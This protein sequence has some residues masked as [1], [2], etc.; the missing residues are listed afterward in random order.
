VSPR[1]DSTRLEELHIEIGG[2]W[3]AEDMAAFLHDLSVLYDIR[4]AIDVEPRL[5]KY[6]DRYGPPPFS[7]GPESWWRWLPGPPGPGLE[8]R[9]IKY[10]SPGYIDL[11][12]LGEAVKQIRLLIERLISFNETRRE[13]RLKND[14]REQDVQAKMIENARDFLRLKTEVREQGFDDDAV[15]QLAAVIEGAQERTLRQIERGNIKQIGAA[16]K[17]SAEPK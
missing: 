4:H 2:R 16:P 1:S 12:G 8:I 7:W 6:I 14:D 3:S 5:L 13:A 11:K 9:R 10:S 15:S 17:G